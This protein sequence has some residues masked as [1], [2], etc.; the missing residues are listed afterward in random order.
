MASGMDVD[1]QTRRLLGEDRRAHHALLERG[2]RRLTADLADDPGTHAGAPGALERRGD[3]VAREIVDVARTH[4]TRLVL[5][6]V[7]AAAHDDVRAGGA[8]DLDE[9]VRPRSEP[10]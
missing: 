9:R 6:D 10:A 8:R 7:V 5:V 1:R 3:H 2:P 4:L